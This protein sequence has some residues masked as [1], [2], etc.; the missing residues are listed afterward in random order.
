MNLEQR[1]R[2]LKRIRQLEGLLAYARQHDDADE[3][4]RIRREL[5]ELVET[6]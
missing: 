6:I 2:I 3:A 5:I 4:E 1:T